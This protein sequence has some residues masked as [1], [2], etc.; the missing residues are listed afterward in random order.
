MSLAFQLNPFY[1]RHHHH[2]HH[3]RR[4]RC[5][6]RR[7]ACARQTISKILNKTIKS[8][9]FVRFLSSAIFPGRAKTS[10]SRVAA[11]RLSHI[12]WHTYE[13]SSLT[14]WKHQ[15]QKY[16]NF[17]ME[18]SRNAFIFLQFKTFSINSLHM[19]KKYSTKRLSR[20]LPNDI[21]FE[22][23][24]VAFTVQNSS[25]VVYILALSALNGIYLNE[26]I[27]FAIK[28]APHTGIFVRLYVLYDDCI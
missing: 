3:R 27:P 11:H 28:W 1:Y 14:R 2:H 5:R 23:V 17:S 25:S 12:L 7:A 22:C 15:T 16:N 18:L 20:F 24:V 4:S 19:E 21:D 9:F 6:C 13:S 8:R 10:M 26:K